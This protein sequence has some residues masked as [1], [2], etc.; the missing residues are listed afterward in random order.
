MAADLAVL[1]RVVE[2]NSVLAEAAAAVARLMNGATFADGS[3]KESAARVL[4]G[5][6]W[7]SDPTAVW[8]GTIL[9]W[10]MGATSDSW[11]SWNAGVI[12]QVRSKQRRQ[13]ESDPDRGSFDPALGRTR[14]TETALRA[15]ALGIAWRFRRS[16][17]FE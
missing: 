13:D 4:E 3:L 14:A 11:K 6:G 12:H 16:L 10:N 5:A 2:P 8:L 1:D 9:A 17:G 7:E 15:L